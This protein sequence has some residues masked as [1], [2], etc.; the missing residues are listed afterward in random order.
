[1]P[2]KSVILSTKELQV[3]HTAEQLS[4]TLTELMTEWNLEKKMDGCCTGNGKNTVNAVKSL[5]MF[6]IPCVGHTLQLSVL[7][8]FELKEVSKMLGRL[9][10]IA[11]HFYRSPKASAKLREK[12]QLPGAPTHKL[13]NDC[14]KRWGSMYA[15]LN[16]FIEQ[17]QAICAASLD[18]RD[19]RQF[20]ASDDEISAAEE[21]LAVLEVFHTATEIVSGEKYPTLG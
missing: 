14:V 21:L 9:R 6:N 17:Q 3:E 20:M 5:D 12:H 4:E 2:L 1:M 15:M 11:G 7:K 19:A 13:L 8:S 10:K 18:S 16:R